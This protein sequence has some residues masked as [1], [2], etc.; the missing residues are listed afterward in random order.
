M[1]HTE[2]LSCHYRL[3]FPAHIH[4]YHTVSYSKHSWHIWSAYDYGFHSL[5]H[6]FTNSATF[7]WPH[8][9]TSISQ[10]KKTPPPP[11][12]VPL[13]I[14]MHT[15]THTPPT[16]DTLPS[17]T[18]RFTRMKDDHLL[19]DFSKVIKFAC[20]LTWQPSGS[21]CS[22]YGYIMRWLAPKV[23][24]YDLVYNNNIYLP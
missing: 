24:K 12:E 1:N 14:H 8:A 2:R 7:L 22:C 4:S 18:A 17:S 5:I 6:H 19:K 13:C 9:V 16:G 15:H 3:S 23:D 10:E 11:K 20:G 21:T